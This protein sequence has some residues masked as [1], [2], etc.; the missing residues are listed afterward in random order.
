MIEPPKRTADA[1]ME[2]L[3]CRTRSD[4]ELGAEIVSV[5]LWNNSGSLPSYPPRGRG[6]RQRLPTTAAGP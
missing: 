1:D 4:I 3:G 6:N 2:V 5:D